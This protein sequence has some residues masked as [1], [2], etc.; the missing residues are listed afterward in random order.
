[1]YTQQAT[2]QLRENANNDLQG[3]SFLFGNVLGGGQ[4]FVLTKGIGS[5][6]K[7]SNSKILSTRDLMAPR[8][9]SCF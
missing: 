7:I 4:H 3:M 5:D 2:G 6:E 9:G 8:F 1:M